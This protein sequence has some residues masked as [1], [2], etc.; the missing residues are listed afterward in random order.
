MRQESGPDRDAAVREG[1]V[2][3]AGA[4]LGGGENFKEEF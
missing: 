4:D 1:G 3:D 2:A